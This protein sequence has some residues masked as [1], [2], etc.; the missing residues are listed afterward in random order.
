MQ[1]VQ[2]LDTEQ[3]KKTVMSETD[4][5]IGQK[6]SALIVS[7]SWDKEEPVNLKFSHPIQVQ[8]SPFVRGSIPFNQI[9]PVEELA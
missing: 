6:Y 3:L 7:S 8:V 5:K 1:K 9:V 4:L 2:G